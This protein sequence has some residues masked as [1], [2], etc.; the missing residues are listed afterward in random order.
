MLAPYRMQAA[1]QLANQQ[2]GVYVSAEH[3][4][5]EKPFLTQRAYHRL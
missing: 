1:K 4:V 5:R 2:A 3:I